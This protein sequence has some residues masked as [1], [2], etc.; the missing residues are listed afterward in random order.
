MRYSF[1]IVKDAF[2]NASCQVRKATEDT[3]GRE[4]V[5]TFPAP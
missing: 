3:P 1:M 4:G 5:R 2:L